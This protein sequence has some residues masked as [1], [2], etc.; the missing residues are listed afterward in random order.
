MKKF[1]TI[2][3]AL[4]LTSSASAQSCLPEGITFITQTE[5]DSFLV[6]Y[7]GCVV[8]EGN[9]LI[10]GGNSI[11]DLSGLSGLTSVGGNLAISYS[12]LLTSL[13]GLN[14]L[15]SIGGDLNIFGNDLLTSLTGLDGINAGSIVNLRIVGND[16]L[17]TCAIRS[18]CDYLASPN[19]TIE[20]HT[21]AASCN[22][23]EE[24][25]SVCVYLLYRETY[26]EPAVVIFPNPASTTITIST[27]TTPDKNSF[28]TIFS[29][30]GHKLIHRQIT[31][32][33]MVVDVSG[34]SQGI[35]FVRFNNNRTMLVSK[36]VK[37]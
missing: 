28:L 14:N 4:F 35:Y 32:Q 10:K 37:Q 30:D 12:Y 33:H 13:S 18:I 20:I 31:G 1:Y 19:G 26:F 27:P 2:L 7:P 25:D 23:P 21:N 36:F 11:V 8:I 15:T 22:S 29:I 34:L 3:I 17:S 5:I 6:N 16:A 9:V 24:V